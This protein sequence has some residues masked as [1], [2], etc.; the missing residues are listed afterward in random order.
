MRIIY[1]ELTRSQLTSIYRR[2]EKIMDSP[3]G[4]TR[5]AKQQFIQFELGKIFPNHIVYVSRN[6]SYFMQS[7]KGSPLV[8][9]GKP[10]FKALIYSPRAYSV[11]RLHNF[12]CFSKKEKEEFGLEGSKGGN[13]SK[14]EI[15]RNTMMVE[16]DDLEQK[17]GEVFSSEKVQQISEFITVFVNKYVHDKVGN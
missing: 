14:V 4:S 5:K 10:G 17:V 6:I 7:R 3:E 8:L 9:A 12:Q 16:E 11:P 1:S 13:V 15:E 2:I